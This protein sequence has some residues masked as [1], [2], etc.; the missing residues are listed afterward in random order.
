MNSST[1]FQIFSIEPIE[2]FV[3]KIEQVAKRHSLC[4]EFDTSQVI[5]APICGNEYHVQ[6]VS[7][8]IEPNNDAVH[9]SLTDFF[10]EIES[11][12]EE[13]ADGFVQIR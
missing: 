8:G 2:P 5:N 10:S 7:L 11:L 3:P 12:T 6:V 13:M 9:L 4:L 1:S